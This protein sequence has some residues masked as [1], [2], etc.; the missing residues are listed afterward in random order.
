MFPRFR[1]V[2]GYETVLSPGEV[3][4]IPAYWW[5]YIESERDSMTVSL[6]FWFFP[7]WQGK[8]E[9]DDDSK[10]LV[11]EAVDQV[12]V[13]REIESMI[14]ETFHPSKVKDVLKEMLDRRF[15]FIQAK[16]E[17]KENN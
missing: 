16:S 15:D 3:L 10:D 5:H 13:R 4:Y 8:D 12:L 9:D 6:N 14:A 11:P 1:E 2:H 17:E 7:A